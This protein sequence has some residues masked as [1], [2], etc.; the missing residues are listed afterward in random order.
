MNTCRIL[1]KRQVFVMFKKIFSIIVCLIFIYSNIYFKV[2][3]YSAISY[4][5]YYPL[6]NEFLDYCNIDKQMTMASTTK[7][8]TGFIA[9]N[10]PD[11]NKK[12]KVN[13][14]M[15]KVEGTSAGLCSGDEI[16][17][18]ELCYGLMLESG[19]DCAN[20]IAYAICGS[21]KSFANLMNETALKLGMKSS[22]FVT[23]SGLDSDG[24][25]TTARDMAI[26]TAKALE[27]DTFKKIVSTKKHKAVYNNGNTTRTY[28]N[29]NRLLSEL[30][31]CIGVK[32][33]F[34]KKSGRCLVSACERDGASVIVVTLNASD[35]WNDN[36]TLHKN[37][38]SSLKK[39]EYTKDLPN[40][41]HVCGGTKNIV[42]IKHNIFSCY[43]PENSTAKIECKI[44]LPK[45]LYAPLEYNE[46]VGKA[47]YYLND[48]KIGEI[49]FTTAEKSAIIIS[50][51][52]ISFIDYFFKLLFV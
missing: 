31:G 14:D 23:P 9:C 37:A 51:N 13:S 21:L 5:V 20:C 16:S 19:N 25:Y 22:H 50:E 43:L 11:L 29:H 46:Q 18:F 44:M 32:T 34:T 10:Q 4:A 28:S 17:L 30:D 1:L 49:Q 7:I 24:H 3:A 36:K 15:L 2:D 45:Y 35:D 27:N 48:K 38:F 6:T 39:Y 26:L 42:S 12:I 33:G 47:V 40:K 52:K 41:V 8:L